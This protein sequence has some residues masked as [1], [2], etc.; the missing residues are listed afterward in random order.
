[1]KLLLI[2]HPSILY[3]FTGHLQLSME[4]E[5]GDKH[6]HCAL[7]QSWGTCHHTNTMMMEAWL[8]P[9]LHDSMFRIND[10]CMSTTPA[11]RMWLRELSI[12]PVYLHFQLQIIQLW[13]LFFIFPL[14][15]L[16]Y[17]QCNYKCIPS[18]CHF[19]CYHQCS[20]IINNQ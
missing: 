7:I 8:Q 12:V 5:S 15:P 20:C 16:P 18:C 6:A 19:L 11:I 4:V 17:H 3:P 2:F 13:S 10:N 9:I 1:M 14:F